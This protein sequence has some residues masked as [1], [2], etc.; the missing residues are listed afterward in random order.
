M[1]Q[2]LKIRTI[3][4]PYFIAK[5]D[6]VS[7]NTVESFMQKYVIFSKGQSLGEY[8]DLIRKGFHKTRD[9]VTD[10]L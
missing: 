1:H 8:A 2:R 9:D 6:E 7:G 10:R 3:S 4:K 5:E